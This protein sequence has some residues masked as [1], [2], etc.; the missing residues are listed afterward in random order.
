MDYY[1]VLGVDNNAST[2]D[3][4]RAFKKQAKKWHPDKNPN[5]AEEA[6]RRFKEV[7]EAYQVLVDEGKR[8]IYDRDGKEGVGNIKKQRSDQNFNFPRPDDFDYPRTR[9]KPRYSYKGGFT[10]SHSFMFKD[11]HQVFRDVFGANDPFEDFFMFD[12]LKEFFDPFG[13]SGGPRAQRTNIQHCRSHN[14]AYFGLNANRRT[15][16]PFASQRHTKSLFDELD[17]IESLF[18]DMMGLGGLSVG[19]SRVRGSSRNTPRSRSSNPAAASSSYRKPQT[20]TQTP[21]RY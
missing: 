11:P 20:S 18:G 5:N 7:S 12:P 21:R 14:P 19:R 13:R 10:E 8:K 15:E 1:K 3:V 4:K 17:E 6:T 9:S 2:E 16:F